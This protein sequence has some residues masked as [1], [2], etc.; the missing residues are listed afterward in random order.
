MWVYCIIFAMTT[1]VTTVSM[2]SYNARVWQN[3]TWIIHYLDSVCAEASTWCLSGG[4][5]NESFIIYNIILCNNMDMCTLH[6]VCTCMEIY[7]LCR[8]TGWLARQH[9][10]PLFSPDNTQLFSICRFFEIFKQTSR[11]HIF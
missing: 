2:L 3:T 11:L 8:Y 6:I 4:I 10:H 9:V 1:T 5:A 7:N